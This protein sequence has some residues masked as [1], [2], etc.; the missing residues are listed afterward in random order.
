MKAI[1]RR[2]APTATVLGILLLAVG[3]SRG[4]ILRVDFSG[5]TTTFDNTPHSDLAPAPG[6]TFSGYYLYDSNTPPTKVESTQTGYYMSSPYG[7]HVQEGNLVFDSNVVPGLTIMEVRKASNED[8]FFVDSTSALVDA[9]TNQVVFPYAE[10]FLGFHDASKST[11]SPDFSLPTAAFDPSSLSIELYLAGADTAAGVTGA[12]GFGLNG[13][14]TSL[15]LTQIAGTGLTPTDPQLPVITEKGTFTFA[16]AVSGQWFDP[17]PTTGGFLYQ[18]TSGALFTHILGFPSGF[19][20][21]FEVVVNGTVIG[22]FGPG[23]TVDFTSFPGGGVS[24]FE[25]FG[26]KPGVD[27]S[28]ADAFPL[29]LTFNTT[30]AN[31][32]MS[33]IPE[34]SSVILVGTALVLGAGYGVRRG[35]GR[36]A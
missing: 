8:R 29:Q 12:T 19:T 1:V 21:P 4:E 9:T 26:I 33:A 32:T 23:D 24:S 14:V 5:Y 36:I 11:L 30:T 16:D 27:P 25:I 28:Q 6:T 2:C 22:F 15:T 7:M 3:T 18:M 35:R 31:F 10:A 13:V 34:P 20:N 17:P